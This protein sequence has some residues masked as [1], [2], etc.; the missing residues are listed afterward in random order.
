VEGVEARSI[1]LLGSIPISVLPTEPG[2]SPR[3]PGSQATSKVPGGP[4]GS[5]SGVEKMGAT[6]KAPAKPS[7]PRISV[8]DDDEEMHLFLKDLEAP[9]HFKIVG[10][11]YTAAQALD[12]LPLDRPDA[13]IMDIRLPDSSGIDCVSK[14]KTILPELPVLMLTGFPDRQSFFRSLMGGARGFLVKPV[15]PSELLSGMRDVIRG[16]FAL[17][18]HVTPLLVQL[19]EQVSGVVQQS[20]LSRRE[21]EI[22]ICL[23]HGMSDKEISTNL[24]IGTATVHTHIHRMFEKL[25]VRSRREIV[26]KYLQIR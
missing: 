15:S 14:L 2:E 16:E 25:G 23:F 7:T 3:I 6:A 1:G 26:A 17:A 24:G 20:G 22:L 12:G 5:P 11:F 8:V 4:I 9:D 18:R 19:V 21:E 10:S 13:V